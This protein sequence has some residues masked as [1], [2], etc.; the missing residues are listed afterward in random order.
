VKQG[1]RLETD[2]PTALRQAI[3][4]CRKGGTVSVPGVYGGFIDK[5]PVGAWFSK[6]L[7]L[8]GGQT[9]VHRYLAPLLQ[10]IQACEVDPSFVITHR[11]GLDDVPDA[12][13]MFQEKD[14]GCVK[15]VIR[16]NGHP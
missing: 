3:Q 12:Y 11:I 7:T 8:K 15:V 16:P 10:R 13:R 9:H 1:L 5:A 6:G 2:R 4:A 14:D